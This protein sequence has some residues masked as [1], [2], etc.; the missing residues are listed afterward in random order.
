LINLTWRFKPL[1]GYMISFQSEY[2]LSN[3]YHIAKSV[4]GA[5]VRP[6]MNRGLE[7]RRFDGKSKILK[8]YSHHSGQ[9]FSQISAIARSGPSPL[10]NLVGQ[11]LNGSDGHKR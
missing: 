6:G 7:L 1:K 8:N 9:T 10:S 2:Q 3:E 4:R 11:E 5:K